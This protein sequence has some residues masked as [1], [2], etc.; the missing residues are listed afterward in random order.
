[1]DPAWAQVGLTFLGMTFMGGVGWAGMRYQLRETRNTLAA[2]D[3]RIDELKRD[4]EHDRELCEEH[5]KDRIKDAK[6]AASSAH[7]RLDKIFGANPG[8]QGGPPRGDPVKI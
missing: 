4:T 5:C 1:M 6:E 2:V 7:K 8:G 3:R